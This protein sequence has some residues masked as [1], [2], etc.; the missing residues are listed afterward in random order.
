MAQC[1]SKSL[2][3]GLQKGH[4]SCFQRKGKKRAEKQEA[5]Q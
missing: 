3:E 2:G 4:V 1:F 5:G